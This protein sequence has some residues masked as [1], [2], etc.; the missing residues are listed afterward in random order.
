L[1]LFPL[2]N[3]SFEILLHQPMASSS[4][5]GQWKFENELPFNWNYDEN[6]WAQW[7]TRD[8]PSSNQ[9]GWQSSWLMGLEDPTSPLSW[10]SW[11]GFLSLILIFFVRWSSHPTSSS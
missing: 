7:N 11:W 1:S 6:P 9:R 4:F 8:I 5:K 2:S 10:I 3:E